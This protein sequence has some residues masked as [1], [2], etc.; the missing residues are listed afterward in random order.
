MRS[1]DDKSMLIR[2]TGVAREAGVATLPEVELFTQNAY[3]VFQVVQVFLITTLSSA[4]SATLT[5]ILENPSSA[6]SILA[7]SIPKASNFYVSYFVLQGFAMSASRI[8]HLGSIFRFHIM[9]GGSTPRA[10]ARQWHRLRRIRWGAVYPVF[11]NMAVI[12]K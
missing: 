5:T 8:V 3:F 2:G 11:T 9:K 4:I 7:H 10:T 6:E 1:A 12:G